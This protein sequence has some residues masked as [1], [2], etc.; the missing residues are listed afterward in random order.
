MLLKDAHDLEIRRCNNL[1]CLCNVPSLNHATELKR[2]YLSYCEGIEHILCSSSFSC[3][4]P[5]QTPKILELWQLDNLR[6]LFLKEKDASTQVP[7]HT[8]SRLKRIEIE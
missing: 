8:F 5:L 6:V 1:R 4:L 7:P 3:T 2:I